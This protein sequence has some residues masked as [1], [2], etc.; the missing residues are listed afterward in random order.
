MKKTE[1]PRDILERTFDFKRVIG[2][3]VVRDQFLILHF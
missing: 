3:I 2:A 1:P